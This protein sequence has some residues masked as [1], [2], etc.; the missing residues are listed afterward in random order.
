MPAS[1]MLQFDCL[2]VTDQQCDQRWLENAVVI[3]MDVYNTFEP[4]LG[5]YIRIS[6]FLIRICSKQRDNT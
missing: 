4:L 2:Q 3:G 6:L 5:E 1:E